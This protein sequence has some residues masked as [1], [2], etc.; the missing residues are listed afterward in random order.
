MNP[1]SFTYA[2]SC[3]ASCRYESP[4]R[5]DA[6]C[7]SYT[8]MGAWC[9]GRAP[10]AAIHAASCHSYREA[11]TTEAFAGGTSA[12]RAIGSARRVWLP[13]GRVMSYLYRAPAPTPGRNSSHTP[14]A[15]SERIGYATESQ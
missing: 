12:D 6:R 1:S 13:S 14:L 15:P 9:A 5:Q 4:G 10:R 7:S 11:V 2:G 8:D 3:S